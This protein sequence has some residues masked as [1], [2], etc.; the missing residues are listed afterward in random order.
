MTPTEAASKRDREQGRTRPAAQVIS[1][2][3]RTDIPAF[4]ADWFMNRIQ[5][6][7]AQYAN[8]FGGQVYEVALRPEDVIALVFWSRNYAPLLPHLPTLDRR[9][10]AGYFH[11]TLTGLGRPLEPHA[12]DASAVIETL[13][14]LAERYSPQHV[15]WRFDPLIL[16][17]RTPANLL[18]ERFETLARRLHGATTRCYFSFVDYYR[19]TRNNLQ[20]LIERG[21]R[22]DEPDLAAKLDLTR[23]LV[24]IGRRYQMTLHACCEPEVLSVPGVHQAHCV[25]AD[26]IRRL[27]PA[28]FQT[29]KKTPTRRGCGCFASRDI[30]AYETCMHGCLYCYAN[31]SHRKAQ[32]NYAAHTPL[33][34]GILHRV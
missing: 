1:V 6:G 9:G 17:N 26:L 22:F 24:A 14:A 21:W 7:F 18:L 33:S 29:L 15:L 12:P 20:P 34:P 23:Q 8:P 25:D 28:K 19:K 3:R 2:S 31:A 27:F 4:Y 30:G 16:S 11:C 13:H 5:A 10:Y 32:A